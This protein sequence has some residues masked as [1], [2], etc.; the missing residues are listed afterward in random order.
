MKEIRDLKDLTISACSG[1]YSNPEATAER[2]I[3]DYSNDLKNLLS[4]IPIEYHDWVTTKY[5]SLYRAWLGS[6]TPIYS[7]FISGAS[8][9]PIRRMEKLNRWADNHYKRFSEWRENIVNRVKRWEKKKNYSLSS[10][11]EEQEEKLSELKE[12]QEAMK[13]INKVVRNKKLTKEEVLDELTNFGISKATAYKLLNPTYSYEK[14][15]FQT[16]QLSNNNA[17]IKNTEARIAELQKR[18]DAEGKENESY[19]INGVTVEKDI[20]ANRIKLFFPSKP[21]EKMRTALKSIGFRWSPN[22]ECWQAYPS[23]E[24]KVKDL[25]T[26]YSAQQ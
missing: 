21:D 15:G 18:L 23:A 3:N 12:W 22:N 7:S 8:N 10:E 5:V 14:K 9:F 4:Q 2:N 13:A 19:T 16:W 24:W 25:L 20:A 1:I 17:K 6:Q 11:I 26:D